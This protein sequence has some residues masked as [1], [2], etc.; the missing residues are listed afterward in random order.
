MHRRAIFGVSFFLAL[1]AWSCPA[2]AYTR[3]ALVIGNSDYRNF[4]ELPNP[5]H[6]AGAIARMFEQARFNSVDARVDLSLNEFRVALREF[7]AKSANAD[8]AV[9]YYAGHGVEMSGANYL[10][11]VDAKLAA[12]RDVEDEAVSLTSVLGTVRA[13]EHLRLIILDACRD[14][15]FAA[16][17]RTASATR[18]VAAGRLG[19]APQASGG[20][21]VVEVDTSD[22]YVAFAAK[23]GVDRAY[24]DGGNSP[25][26][27]ALVKYLATP[28]L[29]VR[30]ALGKVRDEVVDATNRRQEPYVYGSLGGDVIS[31][32]PTPAQIAALSPTAA[33][34]RSMPSS[35]MGLP[36][37]VRSMHGDWQVRCQLVGTPPK[38][39]CAV[40]QSVLATDRANL[41]LTTIVL[42]GAGDA[43]LLLRVVAPTGVLLTSGL[44][45]KVDGKDIGRAG[46]VRCLP[47]GCVAEIKLDSKLLGQLEG[48]KTGTFAGVL[49]ASGERRI[50][51][52]AGR[53]RRQPG[54]AAL[55]GA[56]APLHGNLS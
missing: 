56:Q 16:R 51:G 27:T 34:A 55:K 20:L 35:Q 12:D 45:F 40:L 17:M 54:R 44:G 37:S 13:V 19:N 9:I 41:G 38:D 29:D 18:A 1:L 42:K 5:Q 53:V 50:P 21:A 7:A 47:S 28:G 2:A 33:P 32:V 30:M 11:P 36:G 48:G 14:N 43:G 10:I 22:T 39:Q 3:V 52:G 31:L 25:F 26:T 6:D 15:P 4:G 24:G 23:A 46:F 49:D 8:V